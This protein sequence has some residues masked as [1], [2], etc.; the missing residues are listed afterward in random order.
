[1]LTFSLFLLCLKSVDITPIY[2]KGR[3]DFKGNYRPVSIL[4][5]LSKLYE[6][7]LFKQMANFFRKYF[8]KKQMRFQK[9]L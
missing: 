6:R 2:K 8:L 3:K 7:S 9:I 4:P 1:M 5:A